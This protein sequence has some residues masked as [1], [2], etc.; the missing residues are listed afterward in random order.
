MKKDGVTPKNKGFEINNMVSGLTLPFRYRRNDMQKPKVSVIMPVYNSKTYLRESIESIIN[1]S[2]QNWEMIIINE[3]DS[4]DGSK[5]IILEYA[6]KDIR[7]IL[8]QNNIKLGLAESLNIGIR[9]AQGKYVARMDA[10]DLSHPNRLEKQVKLMNDNPNIGICGTYQRHFGSDINWIHKPPITIEE[11]RANLLF[12]CDLCHSTLML[13]KDAIIKYN[14]F[15]DKNYLAEDFE[16]WTRAVTVTDIIN[17]PEIL[18]EYRWGS[19]NITA[20][21]KSKLASENAVIVANSL[22]RNLDMDIPNDK[23]I[24]LEGWRNPFKEEK[25]RIV[26][27]HMYQDFE[28]LLTDIYYQNKRVRFYDEYALLNIIAAKWRNVRYLE[29]RNIKRNIN[30]LEEIFNN[31]YF[32]NLSMIFKQYLSIYPTWKSRLLKIFKLIRKL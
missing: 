4:N 1:Q 9:L 13:R 12:D 10:D 31:Y 15:Y 20:T 28:K 14:L 11:C 25:N 16:L 29:P 24:L 8:I 6:K 17:I 2:Y 21:K 5:N 32:P 23:Y 26:R 3:C 27:K 30:S 22:K 7:I 18:G 19:G